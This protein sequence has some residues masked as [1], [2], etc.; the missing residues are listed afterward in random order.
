MVLDEEGMPLTYEVY[1]G[2][3][4]ESS[5]VVEMIKRLKEAWLSMSLKEA[6]WELG[7]VAAV[8]IEAKKGQIRLRTEIKGVRHDLF[9]AL[10]VKIPG[11]VLKAGTQ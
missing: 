5:T 4:F 8:D 11:V 10:Q 6:L 9:R 1:P 2:N 7:K 3:T